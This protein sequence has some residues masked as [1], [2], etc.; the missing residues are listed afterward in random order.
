MEFGL[1]EKLARRLD[2]PSE[3]LRV[4]GER[5]GGDAELGEV[6]GFVLDVEQEEALCPQVHHEFSERNFRHIANPVK[7]AFREE[8]CPDVDSIEAPTQFAI[9]PDLKRM[10]VA[11][12]LQCAVGGAEVIRDPA[13][14]RRASAG[15]HHFVESF[16]KGN[17]I[18]ML[19]QRASE[20]TG[21]VGR[22]EGQHATFGRPMPSHPT[23]TRVAHREDAVA[24]GGQKIVGA[25]ARRLGDN[26]TQAFSLRELSHRGRCHL[27]VAE[28]VLEVRNLTKNYAGLPAVNAV[29]FSIRAGEVL[30]YLGHNGAGKSTTVKML[31]GLLE[32]TSGEV[33]F[34]GADIRKDLAAYKR[35]V[36]Y[37]PEESHLYSFLTGWEYLDLV[38]TLRGV[39]L[40]VREDKCVRM[41]EELSLFRH[42]HTAIAAY[43][44][45]MRQRIMLIAALLDDPEL[46]I[47]DEPFSGLDVVSALVMRRL[48]NLLAAN[49]KAIFFCSPVLETVEK[50]CT[51]LVVLRQG[52]LVA[53]GSMQEILASRSELA[54]SFF[55][56]TE[57]V[58][59]DGIAGR[60]LSA[61]AAR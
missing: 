44:K 18:A 35:R 42:R 26:V 48:L 5:H 38:G 34:H 13:M 28:T 52:E 1:Q 46:L 21:K 58:D 54:E 50:V 9:Y 11:L 14:V 33:C 43:S 23:R 53:S 25:Q 10:R 29:N 31:A 7:L 4:V 61:I 37:V 57:Q 27:D 45:G 15:E 24:V 8:R 19:L 20:R 22:I 56:L 47:L 17:A 59:A 41:L 49:G 16:V 36:G 2:G 51:H 12:L 3:Q 30:G 60:I 40:A 39:P 55:Q 32:P 6:L